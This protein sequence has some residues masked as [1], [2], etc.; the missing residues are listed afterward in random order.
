V[1]QADWRDARL[2]SAEGTLAARNGTIS[3]SLVRSAQEALQL[4]YGNAPLPPVAEYGQLALHFALAQGELRIT[5][6]CDAEQSLLVNRSQRV[7]LYSTPRGIEPVMLAYALTPANQS[8]VS[9]VRLI[10]FILPD[11]AAPA[12]Q[13][14]IAR[15]RD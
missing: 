6:L 12:P 13:F 4:E 1:T 7:M 11:D 3:D 14:R 5:G 10:S 2:I 8:V 9:A 15:E